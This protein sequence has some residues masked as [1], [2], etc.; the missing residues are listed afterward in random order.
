M[1]SDKIQAAVDKQEE[2]TLPSSSQEPPDDFDLL[3]AISK[4]EDECEKRTDEWLKQAGEAAPKCMENLSTVLLIA[5]M[6]GACFWNCPGSSYEAHLVQYM[7]ARA[8]SFGRAALRLGRLGF[9]DEALSLVRS[10]GEIANLLTL[11]TFDSEAMVEWKRSDWHS[12]QRSFRPSQVRRRALE[13]ANFVPM[14]EEDYRL[15]C[16]LSTHPV[17]E[18][19]PQLYNPHGQVTTGGTFQPAG[20]LLVL[21][22]T[23]VLMSVIA[24]F[25]A[26]LCGV[27]KDPLRNIKEAAVECA[28]EVGNVRLT[29]YPAILQ[30]I[31]A[32]ESP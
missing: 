31:S 20:M 13:R 17:P 14:G 11:F 7:A 12:R 3:E 27:P 29:N 10:L 18:L 30:K 5:E 22:E 2:S 26:K 4:G 1:Q 6:V 32:G 24:L 19:R 28:K 8:S 23:S 25:A 9:Y 21:N 16:E 15:L